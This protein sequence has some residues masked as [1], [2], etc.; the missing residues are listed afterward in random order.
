[1]YDFG[2]ADKQQDY[3]DLIPVGTLARVKMEIRYPSEGDRGDVPE[4]TR[5][6]SSSAQYLDCEFTIL[7][8]PMN[9]RKFW[10]NIMFL[11]TSEKALNISR[12]TLRAI[13][14]SA[15]GIN[16][17]DMSDLAMK[18]RRVKGLDDFHEI[19][20]AARIGIERGKDGYDDKN[21]LQ[22]A[23]TPDKAE[24]KQVMSGV[25]IPGKA[26]KKTAK[27]AASTPPPSWG[28]AGQQTPP[29]NQGPPPQEQPAQ[30]PPVPDW[31]R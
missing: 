15:R 16:P 3:G 14:E 7:S 18:A 20:F 21:K 13:L 28:D 19:E 4:L 31:A 27:P 23:L 5:S 22:A 1:M 24:Y 25:T 10:Q 2:N 17:D 26:V 12:A 30:G 9:G 8:D 11:G 29:P 6:T